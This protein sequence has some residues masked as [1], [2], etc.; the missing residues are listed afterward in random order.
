[1]K[2]EIVPARSANEE[3]FSNDKLTKLVL[4]QQALLEV[5]RERIRNL[6]EEM[7]ALKVVMGFDGDPPQ[8]SA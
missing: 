4:L 6:E 3:P 8:G 7:L 1:M 2:E 5:S